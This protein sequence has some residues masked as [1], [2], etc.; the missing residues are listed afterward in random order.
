LDDADG[1][2]PAAPQAGQQDPEVSVGAA[3]AWTRR[4]ALENGQLVAQREV[5]EH[6]AALGPGSAEEAWERLDVPEIPS[7]PIDSR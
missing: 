1:I 4:G 7:Y 3:Q 5:L 2:R 6:Q